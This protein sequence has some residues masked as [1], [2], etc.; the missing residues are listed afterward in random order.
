MR[1]VSRFWREEN[2][3]NTS[4]QTSLLLI[5]IINF[6]THLYSN[7]EHFSYQTPTVTKHITKS[8]KMQ[9]LS[10]PVFALLATSV[11]AMPNSFEARD[12]EAGQLEARADCK[13]ILPA[14]N[15][16]HISGQTNCRCPGQVEKCDVWT[17]P[18]GAPNVVSLLSSLSF[19]TAV[20]FPMNKIP[21]SFKPPPP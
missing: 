5:S 20:H 18:G 7:K 21:L 9:F 13:N 10:I 8:F 12:A 17:C 1:A 14:C 11:L 19:P 4:D 3:I 6:L 16:G 2:Y 15:G